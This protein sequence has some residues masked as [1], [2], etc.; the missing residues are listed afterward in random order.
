MLSNAWLVVLVAAALAGIAAPF[1]RDELD[2]GAAIRIAL[3]DNHTMPVIGLGVALTFEKTYQALLWALEAGYRLVD[4]AADATYDN[5]DQVGLAIRDWRN[6]TCSAVEDGV[7]VTTKLWDDSHGFYPAVAAGYQSLRELGLEYMD[8]YLMHSPFGG[9]LVETWDAMIYLMQQ[10]LTRSIGVSN[11]GIA[12]LRALKESGRPLPVVNQIELHPLIYQRRLPLI[13]WCQQHNITIQAYGSLLAGHQES[14][15]DSLLEHLAQRYNKSVAQILLKWAL[16]HG[17]TIIPKSTQ[18]TRIRNNIDIFD[19]VI[20]TNDMSK[21]DHWSDGRPE[22]DVLFYKE[23]WNWNP[24]DEAEVHLGK[25][26]SFW[27][28]SFEDVDQEFI[29]L[30]LMFFSVNDD[31]QYKEYYLNDDFPWEDN[32]HDSD[33]RDDTETVPQ[34]EL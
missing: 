25:V 8:L 22:K 29:Q 24:V 10:N 5:Q 28:N 20:E 2:K 3:R 31:D 11:F 18:K 6:T 34:D 7:F 9:H 16:Q 33:D 30:Q 27:S 26:S 1:T 19:F 21:L 15:Q 23:D 12:H 14:L 4:T 17:F 13:Q 32:R